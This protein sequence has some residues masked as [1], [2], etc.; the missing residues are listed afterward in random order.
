MGGNAA[1]SFTSAVS[2]W[3]IIKN[4]VNLKAG[5]IV[6]QENG[7]SALG[8]AVTQIAKTFNIQVQSY[9][10]AE[11]I[12]ANFAKKVKAAGAAKLVISSGNDVTSRNLLRILAPGGAFVAYA[13]HI[14][15]LAESTGVTVPISAAIFEDVSVNG[16]ELGVWA[17]LNPAAAQEAVTNVANL[18]K[19]K[20]LTLS[21]KSFPHADYA[22]A[23]KSVET[24]ST[25]AVLT[26]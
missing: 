13:G 1:T 4:F 18:F 11:I 21:T 7:S 10:A 3:A 17:K 14:N 16:F 20:T 26:F 15:S 23:V 2:A 24:S 8:Q 12:D 25:A 22:A 9:T 5:D 19:S 6:V